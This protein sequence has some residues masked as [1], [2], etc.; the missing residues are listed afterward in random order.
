[1]SQKPRQPLTIKLLDGK[2][3]D[4][5]S[6]QTTPLDIAKSINQNMADSAI[7]AK[8][9]NE[10][11]DLERPL[12]YDGLLQFLKI[13]DPQGQEVFWHSSAHVLGEALENI[14]G[15]L[16]CY[17]PPIENGFYYD[18][19]CEKEPVSKYNHLRK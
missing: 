19:Y 8:I 10:L 15:G 14:Y 11:W 7:V 9:N 18:M 6:W 2:T 5:L 1:M 3:I 12:E 17:G 4:G 13:D 16:L